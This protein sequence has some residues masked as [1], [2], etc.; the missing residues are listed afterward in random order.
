M[1]DKWLRSAVLWMVM[2]ILGRFEQLHGVAN[3]PSV[4]DAGP[5][6]HSMNDLQPVALC[7]S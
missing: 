3:W 1:F 6:R 2:L 5:N 7:C 4:T